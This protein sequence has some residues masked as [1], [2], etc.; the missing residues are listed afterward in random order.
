M[1]QHGRRGKGAEQGMAML[2]AVI[3]LLIVVTLSAV[4]LSESLGG[5][6]SG[7]QSRKL[8]QTLDAAEAG[9]QQELNQVGLVASGTLA[10]GTSC[11]LSQVPVSISSINGISTFYTATLTPEATTVTVPV[12]TPGTSGCSSS[13]YTQSV[14]TSNPY[15]LITSTGTSSDTTA[16][17]T[18]FGRTL[19]DLVKVTNAVSATTSYT[20]GSTAQAGN[21]NVVNGLL[22]I[23]TPQVVASASNT[24]SPQSSSVSLL[25]G[26]SVLTAGVLGAAA[27]TESNGT[28]FACAGAL[29]PGGLVQI[30]TPS[31]PCS[32]SGS[33]TSGV[34]VDLTSLLSLAGLSSVSDVKLTADAVTAQASEAV[35]AVPTGS[36]SITDLKVV[37]TLLGV[38]ITTNVTVPT[39]A[40]QNLLT[41]VVSAIT[42]NAALSLVAN[43]L[44]NLLSS[45]IT[46]TS[47]YQS[48]VAPTAGGT[49]TV[50]GIHIGVVGNA[51]LS[52]DIGMV[53]V[54]PNTQTSIPATPA[55]VTVIKT[56]QVGQ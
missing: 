17:G 56:V 25:S 18:T 33:G 1:M 16:G 20:E 9:L 48:P 27:E 43:T 47:S 52:A 6:S 12:T 41:A 32:I 15:L 44:S 22:P 36:G 5:I 29:S 21:I 40:N 38:P 28:S 10:P 19:Q 45:A 51:A 30:G 49:L 53:T 2:A 14:V 3:C 8:Q 24:G 50:S 54:G 37:V 55:K 7:S 4:G 42:H 39:G 31:A 26:Q 35:G 23:G 13:K 34:G 11:S 46:L